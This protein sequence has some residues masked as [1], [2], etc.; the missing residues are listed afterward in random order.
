MLRRSTTSTPYNPD[1]GEAPP[2]S[3]R[4]DLL[5]SAELLRDEHDAPGE[6]ALRLRVRPP[7]FASVSD[8]LFSY[9]MKGYNYEGLY[10]REDTKCVFSYARIQTLII[11]LGSRETVSEPK[12]YLLL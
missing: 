4:R 6:R 1:R 11:R 5:R 12:K 10:P 8:I 7:G 2:P 3:C 9:Y